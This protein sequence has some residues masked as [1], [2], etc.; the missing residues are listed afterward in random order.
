LSGEPGV[1]GEIGEPGEIER[2]EKIGTTGEPGERGVLEKISTNSELQLI[3]RSIRNLKRG[4]AAVLSFGLNRWLPVSRARL[5]QVL[6]GSFL[7]AARILKA[8]NPRR[9][10]EAPFAANAAKG[11]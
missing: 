10:R 11:L 2:T 3:T 4:P 8:A 9:S 6:E 5:R 7:K 1:P